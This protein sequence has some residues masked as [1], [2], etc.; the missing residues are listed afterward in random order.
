MVKWG[1]KGGVNIKN[2]KNLE[3]VKA[4]EIGNIWMIRS[5]RKAIWKGHKA[6]SLDKILSL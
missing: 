1:A 5:K 2:R 4:K 3:N 6:P